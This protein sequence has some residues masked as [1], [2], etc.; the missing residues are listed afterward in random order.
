MKVVRDEQGRLLPTGTCW[1]GCKA[2]TAPG[3]FWSPGH[4][5]FAESA[6]ILLKHG[7]VAEFLIAEGFGPEGRNPRAEF[8]DSRRTKPKRV[9]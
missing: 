1:C 7:S 9:I 3:S 4:D 8:K 6:V 5:K 2:N